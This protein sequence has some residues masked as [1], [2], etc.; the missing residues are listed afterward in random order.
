MRQMSRFAQLL[1]LVSICSEVVSFGPQASHKSSRLIKSTSLVPSS[2]RNEGPYYMSSSAASILNNGAN[3]RS[4][5]VQRIK[6]ISLQKDILRDLTACELALRI[7]VVKKDNTTPIIDYATLI[8]KLERDIEILTAR[9]LESMIPRLGNVK[10]QL[11]TALSQQ[12]FSS[13]ENSIIV[14]SSDATATSTIDIAAVEKIDPFALE[15]PDPFVLEELK[16][17]VDE[18]IRILVREDGSVDWEG[19]KASGKEVAKFGTELWERLNGKEESGDLPSISEIF[20]SVQAE[21]P[22]TEEIKSLSAIVVQ[23]KSDI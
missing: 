22:Q 12:G 2:F 8:G 1:F 19:A 3:G 13:A 17:K 16:A 21:Q 20:G 7:E 18:R 15:E 23:A 9:N 14:E 4:S 11:R 6:D 10:D 5:R